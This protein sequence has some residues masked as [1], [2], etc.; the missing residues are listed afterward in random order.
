MAARLLAGKGYTVVLLARSMDKL[1]AVAGEIRATGGSA[2]AYSVDLSQA[3]DAEAVCAKVVADVGVP[4]VLLNNAG[5]GIWKEIEA[6]SMAENQQMMSVPYFAAFNATRGFIDGMLAENR[7]HIINV[8]SP[9]AVLPIPGAVSY[10]VARWAMRGFSEAL[11]GDL[12]HTK[13]AV[14]MYC[15]GHVDTPYFANNPGSL[16]RIPAIDKIIPLLTE[17]KAAR[18]VLKIVRR[19]P[20][21]YYAPWLVGFF[22]WCHRMFPW[23]VN[24][25]VI[26]TGWRRARKT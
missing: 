5:A 18:H 7:G 20:R 23:M 19:R 3:A 11:Y 22:A 13:G 8:T 14:T 4:H 9:A 2:H 26:H 10:G 1:E 24:M 15:P 16:E 6:T 12:Y 21:E 25:V 17:E